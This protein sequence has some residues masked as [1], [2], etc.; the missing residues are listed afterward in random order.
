MKKLLNYKF[1]RHIS[2]HITNLRGW[3]TNRKIVV[4]ES[5]DWGSVRMP[6]KSVYEKFLRNGIPVDKS[7]YLK[8]DSLASEEDLEALFEALNAYRDHKGN[9]P[10]ITANTIVANPDFERIEESGLRE[11]HYELFTK[12]L[13]SYPSHTNSFS[14]WREGQK[15]NLFQPQ[16]HGREHLNVPLWLNLLQDKDPVFLEAF[17]NRFWG[18][19]TVKYK[20]DEVNILASFDSLERPDHSFH[21][22]AMVEGFSIFEEIF[23]Y[24]SESFIA[25]NYVWDSSLNKILHDL[26]VEFIQGMKKQKLPLYRGKPRTYKRHFTGEMNEH[27]QYYF[28]RNCVFEPALMNSGYDHVGSCIKDISAAFLWRKPAII[29]SHRLNYIGYIEPD[30]RSRNLMLLQELLRRIMTIWPDVEFMSSPQLGA[31]IRNKK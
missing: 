1:R 5:D 24:K 8:Y 31:L 20:N 11:Y 13:Q 7:P 26:G 21:E 12:T 4:I 22:T 17:K 6:S 10:V 2:R 28:V 18:I 23:G 25:P 15:L 30:N 19:D 27:G 29:T 3:R 14:L 9:T 16:L